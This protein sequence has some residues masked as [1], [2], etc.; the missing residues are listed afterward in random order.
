MANMAEN[1]LRI[2]YFLE[3]RYP[4]GFI[5]YD[6]SIRGLI[7]SYNPDGVLF[8]KYQLLS[9]LSTAPQ[10]VGMRMLRPAQHEIDV[11]SPINFT[12]MD[13]TTIHRENQTFARW[14][15]ENRQHL[16]STIQA[17]NQVVRQIDGANAFGFQGRKRKSRRH[18]KG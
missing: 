14:L 18:K 3:E 5:Q 17:W 11:I 15:S 13:P 8:V 9:L 12:Y 10:L 4:L 7:N 1:L 16:G 2:M 6:E